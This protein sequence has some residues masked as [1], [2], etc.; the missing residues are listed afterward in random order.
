MFFLNPKKTIGDVVSNLPWMVTWM[1]G[2][3][4]AE[5]LSTTGE[6]SES[7]AMATGFWST[8]VM[9]DF[10]V[11]QLIRRFNH[12]DEQTKTS[13]EMMPAKL[14]NVQLA[15]KNV[16]ASNSWL[17]QALYSPGARIAMML[18]FS[19]LMRIAAA[20]VTTKT[21]SNINH[22]IGEFVDYFGGNSKRVS[23]D[24]T[25]NSADPR[26]VPFHFAHKAPSKNESFWQLLLPFASKKELPW[27]QAE[28]IFHLFP[29]EGN[30]L[31]AVNRINQ[32]VSHCG[33][34]A[35]MP[36]HIPQIIPAQKYFKLVFEM[37]GILPYA[38][39]NYFTEEALADIL[40]LIECIQG[41]LYNFAKAAEKEWFT[42][43][44]ETTPVEEAPKSYEFPLA[45]Y[46]A[47]STVL[48]L[49]TLVYYKG[50]VPKLYKKVSQKIKRCMGCSPEEEGHQ[51]LANSSE[52]SGADHTAAGL[53]CFAKT[54]KIC[55]SFWCCRSK[56]FNNNSSEEMR[57]LNLSK[58]NSALC[59]A[60]RNYFE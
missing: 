25:F 18:I 58:N 55:C 54:R 4:A 9:A 32:M 40:P 22:Q 26:V 23:A 43:V 49:G 2:C 57:N 50:W 53:T 31:E 27:D 46:A 33:Y 35:G 47:T 48:F 37:A 45:I 20:D 44:N 51:P 59:T 6:I 8:I 1:L 15:K 7:T 28:E 3:Q 34:K 38:V 17:I 11:K 14:S 10:C 12:S 30:N 21:T 29:K 56:N 16:S 36:V 42:K 24:T 5:E 13:T 41:G 52:F 19:S 60:G 39:L